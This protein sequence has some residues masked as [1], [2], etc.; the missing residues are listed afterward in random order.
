M[1]LLP[2]H[3]GCAQVVAVLMQAVDLSEEVLWLVLLIHS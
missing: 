2:E 3:V 1:L